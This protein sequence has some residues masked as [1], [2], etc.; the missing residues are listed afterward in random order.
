MI[1][2]KRDP[3]PPK[4]SVFL[5]KTH[6]NGTVRPSPAQKETSR[7][8]DFFTNPA[9]FA[10]NKKITKKSFKFSVYSHKDLR[11]ALTEAFFSKCAYCESYSAHVAPK[12]IEHFRP[13]SE[14]DTGKKTIAPGYYWLAADWSNLLLSC[15]FCNRTTYLDV[16]NSSKQ[17][18][19]GKLTQFR[20]DST[21]PDRKIYDDIHPQS[22]AVQNGGG[23]KD[24]AA[25]AK[26]HPCDPSHA[27]RRLCRPGASRFTVCGYRTPGQFRRN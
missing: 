13:K 24:A 11:R 8:I 2:I 25:K 20:N 27:G 21:G 9:H 26:T 16:P 1:H 5:S 4:L 14:I 15:Q 7:A 19:L 6:R 18:R 10:R 17:V 23:G 22:F 3:T 12:D